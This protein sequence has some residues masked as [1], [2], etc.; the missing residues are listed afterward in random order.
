MANYYDNTLDYDPYNVEEE[1]EDNFSYKNIDSR[2][3][4][5]RSLNEK[6]CIDLSY[7]SR[8]SGITI[9]QLIEELE[10]FAI[11]PD[12]QEYVRSDYEHCFVTASEL[13]RGN[14]VRKHELAKELN[15][16]TAFFD[17][18][19]SYL[20]ENLPDKIDLNDIY[21]N[22]GA[23]WIPVDII[24]R[25]IQELF[26]LMLPPKIELDVIH[27]KYTIDFIQ[28][29][30]FVYDI[31]TYGTDRM[32]AVSIIKH[33][34]NAS[35]IR[36]YDQIPSLDKKTPDNVLN[37]AATLAAQEKERLIREEWQ[38]YIYSHED[39]RK[40]LEEEYYRCWGYTISR[41]DGSFL[42]LD[43]LDKS[44][45][46][47][48][49]QKDAIAHILMS[50][51]VLLAHE[52]GA[53]KTLEYM[54]GVHELIRIGLTRKAM[55]VVP[56]STLEGTYQ[57]YKQYFKDDRVLVVYPTKDFKPSNRADTLEKIKSDDYQVI[58]MAYS[59]FDMITVS[60]PCMLQDIEYQIDQCMRAIREAKHYATKKSLSLKLKHLNKEKKKMKEDFEENPDPVTACFE[61]LGVDMLVVDECHNYKN[62][63]LENIS[64]SIVGV[65][66]KGSKKADDMLRKVSYIQ[67]IDGR[68]VF[69]T[70]TPIT[71]SLADIYVLQ[72]YLQPDLLKACKIDH[73]NEWINTYCSQEDIFEIDIDANNYRV[74]RR[75]SK[76]HNLT[77]LMSTFSEVCDFYQIDSETVGLPNFDGYT[78]ITIKRSDELHDCI[79][80]L[81]QRTEQIRAHEVDRKDDN[82][83]KIVGEGRLYA[84]DIRHKDPCIVVDHDETKVGVSSDNIFKL[85]KAFPGTTQVAFCDVSTPKEGFNV[86]NALKD[87]LIAKGIPEKE[88]AFIHDATSEAQRAKLEKAFN[89]GIIR[90]LIGSTRMLGTGSNVQEHLIAA[91]HI[92]VPWRPADMVQREGRI[93][94]QGN[95]CEKVFIFRYVT[96]SSFDAYSWQILENKQRFIAQFL[97]GSLNAVHRE[98]TDCTDTVLSYAE[99]KALAIG[100]PLI[101]QRVEVANE[102]E[103]ARIKQREK[104]KELIRLSEAVS[105]VLPNKIANLK[106]FYFQEKKDYEYYKSVKEPVPREER[107][108]FGEELLEELG[109]SGLCSEERL[110]DTYQ[111]FGIFLPGSMDI[112]RPYIIIRRNG[113]NEYTIKIDE[114]TTPVGCSM[115]IDHLLEGLDCSAEEHILALQDLNRQKN[116]AEADIEKGN[117]YDAVV[118]HLV[119][120][121]EQIDK[122]LEEGKLCLT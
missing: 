25:F 5:I 115:K 84:V 78:D 55:I 114:D 111:G 54:A 74:K 7:M 28:A 6:A 9:R 117:E 92:D 1:Y 102:L 107:M 29:P 4:F 94:R 91:H 89:K 99:I 10:G 48:S 34:L 2:D 69:A 57:A 12:P 119:L 90:I 80:W 93:I 50:K 88:I 110:F 97:S 60:T 51:N 35:P 108:A 73:F 63:T 22:L 16:K 75:F 27:G 118:K 58:I 71:N 104:R 87:E 17:S 66:G 116:R 81:A 11:W 101:R 103:Q 113:S 68:L 31:S 53:G 19:L 72:K 96:E 106:R 45:T 26:A 120:K 77:E 61:D 21:I 105:T 32:R 46:P 33:I 121:R 112:N 56:N 42:K 44:V 98:E 65:H 67:S 43:D 13:L 14:I 20:K 59:S 70:G 83:L 52:V 3:A 8:V 109:K 41:F 18:T 79:D 86:Y 62:I 122:K 95:T 36:I 49:Y 24:A 64:D 76:F 15:Q 23:T 39:I 47:Y 30:G 85:Y 40:R 38:N 37:K 100:N 82:L